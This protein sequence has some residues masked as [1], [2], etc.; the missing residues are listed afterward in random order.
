M[1]EH[2]SYLK[3]NPHGL[4]IKCVG[5]GFSEYEMWHE[6]HQGGLHDQVQL[7]TAL[8]SSAHKTHHL[9]A[10]VL[11]HEKLEAIEEPFRRAWIVSASKKRLIHKT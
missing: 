7:C 10:K 5:E 8:K 4:R 11:A 9:G 2:T 3:T 6:M 1:K